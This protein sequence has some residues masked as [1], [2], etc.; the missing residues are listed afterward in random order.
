MGK[1]DLK[2][3]KV[4][5][6]TGL[7]GSGKSTIANKIKNHLVK[8]HFI[9]LD[10][11]E[12]REVFSYNDNDNDNK[13]YNYQTRINLA[14]KY[15]RICNLL[16]KQGI[17][18]II[19]TISLFD[20]IHIWNRENIKNYL[21]IYLKVNLEE[22]KK[23]DPKKIYSNFFQGKTSNVAG[24]DID[25]DEPKNPDLV[26]DFSQE[27]KVESMIKI[28]LEKYFDKFGM[29]NEYKRVGQYYRICIVRIKTN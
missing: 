6:I 19:A 28:I 1:I 23:R 26:L 18:V 2:Y 13:N 11:D 5:W 10:G 12:L 22:L 25:I 24:L 14:Y 15:S 20:E 27:K 16:A 4:L 29:A 9:L 7:S 8:E 21:E 3:G 17:N